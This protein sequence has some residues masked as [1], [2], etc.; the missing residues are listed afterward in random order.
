MSKTPKQPKVK[1]VKDLYYG[2]Q[3]NKPAVPKVILASIP[4][5]LKAIP[6]WIGWR[7]YWDQKGQR[8]AKVPRNP[9]LTMEK[10]AKSDDPET[11][12]PFES[13]L[14]SFRSAYRNSGETFNLADGI[15]F[16]LTK[17]SGVFGIDI[18]MCRDP[19]TG[20]LST[21]AK[22]IVR[23]FGAYAEYS[24][25]PFGIH[26]YARGVRPDGYRCKEKFSDGQDLEI[27]DD[28][29]FFTVT[30]LKIPPEALA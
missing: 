24:P 18:D 6:Q 26:I 1:T 25:S 14:A 23:E 22:E 13:T 20:A 29:R 2:D 4:D 8:W 28:G 27:Y 30:G 7:F 10:N 15:G 19:V 17:N 11:W 3:N 21:L 16:V 9:R 5:G 12:W